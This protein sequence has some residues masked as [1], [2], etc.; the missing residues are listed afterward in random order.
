MWQVQVESVEL[1]KGIA[2]IK[3]NNVDDVRNPFQTC[4][5]LIVVASYDGEPWYQ[6]TKTWSA[7]TS[8]E[9]QEAAIEF[10]LSAHQENRIVSFGYIGTGIVPES[11]RNICRVLSRALVKSA[12]GVVSFHDPA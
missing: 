2:I 7:H 9:T 10:L 6:L 1:R 5:P 3:I 4:S 11:K 8:L 12:N